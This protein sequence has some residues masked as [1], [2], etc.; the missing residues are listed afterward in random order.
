M[1]SASSVASTDIT[2][3]T[4]TAGISAGLVSHRVTEPEAILES[5][6]ALSKNSQGAL[7]TSVHHHYV[8]N[9]LTLTKNV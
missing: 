7:P 8:I 2:I 5:V 9:N 1:F 4:T 3:A 6:G